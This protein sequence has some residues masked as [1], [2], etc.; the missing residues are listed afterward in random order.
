[1]RDS[2]ENESKGII[3]PAFAV[4]TMMMLIAAAIWW[5]LQHPFG[6]S[7]DEASYLNEAQIDAQ[8][9]RHGMLLRLAGRILLKSSGRPPAYRILALPVLGTIGFHTVALRL[10]SLTCFVL[11]ALLVYLAV[12]RVASAAGGGFAALIFCLSPI[13]I[14][15]NMWF[16]TEG[17]LYLATAALLY[18]VIRIWYDNQSH[19]SNWVGL[20]TAVGIG[21]LAKASFLAILVPLLVLWLVV[22]HRRDLGIPSLA[23]EWKAGL[24]AFVIAGPWWILNIKPAISYT[25]YARGFV[26]TSLGPPSPFR[27]L[28]WLWTV[29]QSLFGYGV[30][31]VIALVVIAAL[32][33]AMV[34][35]AIVLHSRRKLVLWLCACAGIPLVLAQLTGTNE[36]LRHISPAVIPLAIAVGALADWSGWA[37]ARVSMGVSGVLFCSQ[38]ALI[39]APIFS[40]NNHPVKTGPPNGQYPWRVMALVDQWDWTPVF[41]IS[42]NCHVPS[43]KVSFLGGGAAFD[44]AQIERPWAAAA[45]STAL[46]TFPYPDVTWLWRHEEGPIDWEKVMAAADASDIVITAPRYAVGA[47]SD[48]DPDNQYNSEL[49]ERLS[50]DPHFRKPIRL[51]MGRFEPVEVL[52]FVNVNLAGRFGNQSAS[53]RSTQPTNYDK[54]SEHYGSRYGRM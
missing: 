10:I 30:T 44:P 2:K 25:Q 50:R 15:A 27:W 37:T 43:P 8:R 4:A 33:Q 28:I 45:A 51:L 40:P 39:A 23:K 9:L 32:R 31:I 54:S 49:A 24:L 16:S 1:M 41:E 47:E 17:P 35:K 48:T 19:W 36:L 5:G 46:A 22:E 34:K 11:S 20:G 18:C 14:R 12:R 3:W 13:V 38:L 26:A 6:T 53:G 42:R 52:T 21:L 7:W 29:V